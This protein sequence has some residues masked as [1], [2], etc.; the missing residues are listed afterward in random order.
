GAASGWARNRWC[1]RPA[2]PSRPPA[3]A[4]VT[5]SGQ[6]SGAAKTTG[7]MAGMRRSSIRATLSLDQDAVFLRAPRKHITRPAP[8]LGHA[9]LTK[10]PL[11][12]AAL[13]PNPVRL[14]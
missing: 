2:S 11:Q 1:K 5:P 4:Q 13:R 6:A 14:L 3:S 9:Y 12:D 8:K 7:S 10:A